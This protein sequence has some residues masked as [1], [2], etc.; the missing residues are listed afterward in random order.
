MTTRILHVD[1]HELTCAGCALILSADDQY[2]L[3]HALDK[4]SEV[5]PWLK[6]NPVDVILL[7]IL[8]ADMNGLSL[9]A[10]LMAIETAR[11]IILTGQNDPRQ[12]RF[13]LDMG[14]R[15]IIQKSD[16]GDELLAALNAIDQDEPYLSPSIAMQLQ[17]LGE[18]AVHLSPRQA[19]ILHYMAA[20]ETNKE[21]AG[22]LGIATP[23]VS[24][25]IAEMRKKLAVSHNRKIVQAA[26]E[27]G[28]I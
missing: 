7:D 13:A 18:P 8:L 12:F 22:K 26:R 4:G 23:T 11:V 27:I 5:L 10:E 15:G 14:V 9:L 2:E 28:L 25:H 20:G 6:N 24:F 17:R 1:D 21:I 3:V 19:A 16:P